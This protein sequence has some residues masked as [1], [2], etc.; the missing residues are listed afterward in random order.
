MARRVSLRRERLGLSRQEVADRAGMAVEYL[1]YLESSAGMPDA[2]ALAG[3][4]GALGTSVQ[5]LLGV[6][7]EAP[8]GR[9][10]AAADPVMEELS[11]PVCWSKLAP[12]GIG[13]VVLSTREGPVALPVNF[14]VL[15]GTVVYRTAEGST[16]CA[17][18]GALVAF[19]VDRIDEAVRSGWSVLVRGTAAR[20]DEPEAVEH[21]KHRGNPDPWAGDGRD[22]W[23]RIRPAS[24]TG[25]VIR[26]GIDP[27]R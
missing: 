25:R 13:R 3:L 4:A 18:R 17:D 20:L 6:G 16:A 12:G 24:V 15:D 22:V 9:A 27:G 14:R 2:A 8:P 11:A 21:L 7:L 26:T 19:E 10:A 23:I 5:E 1:E